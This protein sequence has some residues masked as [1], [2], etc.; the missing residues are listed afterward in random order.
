M[1]DASVELSL[2]PSHSLSIYKKLIKLI[3]FLK[4]WQQ[5]IFKSTVVISNLVIMVCLK[6]ILK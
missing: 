2:S 5:G 1:F 3:K 6:K 4:E